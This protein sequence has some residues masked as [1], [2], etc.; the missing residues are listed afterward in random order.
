METNPYVEELKNRFK[1]LPKELQDII[2][3]SGYQTSLVEIGK[4]HKLTIEQ[5]GQLE[6]ET[7]LVMVGSTHPD[8]YVHEVEEILNIDPDLAQA[9]ANDV[10]EKI[11][12]P[13]REKLEEVYYRF[14]VEGAQEEPTI[15]TVT[16]IAP[17]ENKVLQSTGIV[18][19]ERKPTPI[20]PLPGTIESRDAILKKVENPST[21]MTPSQPASDIFMQKLTGT[22]SMKKEESNH[23]LSAMG[24]ATKPTQTPPMAKDSY[25][26]PVE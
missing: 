13:I 4:R 24:D 9:I 23:S 16:S 2:M 20:A 19:E 12:K 7:T 18:V 6:L 25:R 5:L 15:P 26:E 3:S 14:E 8:M 11:M 21:P 22:F 1:L 17:Q 10:N